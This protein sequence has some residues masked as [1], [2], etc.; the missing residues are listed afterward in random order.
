MTDINRLLSL[1]RIELCLNDVRAWMCD[2]QLNVN[3]D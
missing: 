2:N 1:R 3:D